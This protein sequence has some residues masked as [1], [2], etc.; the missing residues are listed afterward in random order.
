MTPSGLLA[1]KIT[2]RDD[3]QRLFNGPLPTLIEWGAVHPAH[4]MPDSGVTWQALD[5]RHP[6]AGLLRNA[7][8]AIGLNSV[9]IT[10]GPHSLI[11]ALHPPKVLCSSTA[12]D[13][14]HNL[15]EAVAAGLGQ[16]AVLL[17]WSIAMLWPV[18]RRLARHPNPT[19][20]ASPELCRGSLTVLLFAARLASRAFLNAAPAGSWR[21]AA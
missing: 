7:Y 1:W 18:K 8:R 21:S 15:G 5:V 11:A 19:A 17:D 6:H 4:N 2:V 12:R 10:Q 13:P 3:G 14:L 16:P 20:T 9:G